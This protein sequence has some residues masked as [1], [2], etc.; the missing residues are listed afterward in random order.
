MFYY[1]FKTISNFV[2]NKSTNIFCNYV[3]VIQNDGF[4]FNPF[5]FK[6]L[7]LKVIVMLL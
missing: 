6:K 3:Y 4:P 7:H 5:M 2:N 1:L